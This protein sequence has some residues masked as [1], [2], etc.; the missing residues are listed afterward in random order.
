MGCLFFT[1]VIAQNYFG[2]HGMFAVLGSRVISSLQSV[3]LNILNYFKTDI[4]PVQILSK[5][6]G[7]KLELHER[8]LKEVLQNSWS[9]P[10]AIVAICGDKRKGKSFLINLLINYLKMV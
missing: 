6:H 1:R 5:N 3:E 7:N 2:P 10:T 8:A 9:M 4:T